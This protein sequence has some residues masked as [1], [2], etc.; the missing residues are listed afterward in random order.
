MATLPTPEESA[1]AILAIFSSP[2]SRPGHTLMAGHVNIAFQ[3][4]G[5]TAAE[6]GAGIKYAVETV[7]WLELGQNNTIKLTDAGFAA[8]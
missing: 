1:R 7:G 5:G 6:F 2:N 3:K 8:M 4:A